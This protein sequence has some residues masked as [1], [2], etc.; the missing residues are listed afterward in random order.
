MRK[1]VRVKLLA[2]VLLC[3]MMMQFGG[4]FVAVI[5][6]GLATLDFCALLGPDCVL[7]PISPCGDPTTAD[8]DILVDCP[9]PIV[10]P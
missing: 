8:D 5:N 10:T 7:G 4:C 6:A 1:R 3:G 9:P 2:A